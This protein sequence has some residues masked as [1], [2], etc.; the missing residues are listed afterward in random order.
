MLARFDKSWGR[1]S[2]ASKWVKWESEATFRKKAG[3][4]ALAV[5]AGA[6]PTDYVLTLWRAPQSHPGLLK[7]FR[8]QIARFE[9]RRHRSI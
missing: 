4:T 1:L 9:A 5:L 7:S 3:H 8:I 6:G 2:G